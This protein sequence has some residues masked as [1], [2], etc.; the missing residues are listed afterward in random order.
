MKIE[1]Y[2]AAAVTGPLGGLLSDGRIE[3]KVLNVDE[4][5][6]AHFTKDY[7]LYTKTVVVSE[8]QDGKEVRW[9]R[10]EKVWDLLGDQQAFMDYV[11]NEVRA[12]VDSGT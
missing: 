6:N 9:K 4:P 3:W 2:T 1:A 5:V 11:S 8:I 10:L 7:E 12:Y